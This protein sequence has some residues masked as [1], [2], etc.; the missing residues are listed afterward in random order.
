MGCILK[1]NALV[2]DE[3]M[4]NRQGMKNENDFEFSLSVS[5]GANVSDTDL[6]KVSVEIVGEKK[7]EYEIKVKASGF[8]V[9][10]GSVDDSIIQQNAVAIIM[11]YVRSEVSLLTAQPGMDT[12]VLPP[13]NIVEMMKNSQKIEKGL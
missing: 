11:P 2:F 3:I 7:E 6:K 9:Y 1:L 8:F 5:I 12:V 10:E 4:F 13:F